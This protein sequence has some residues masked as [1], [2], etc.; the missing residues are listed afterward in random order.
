MIKGIQSDF[1]YDENL[2]HEFFFIA[3]SS[4][5]I[6]TRRYQKIQD[7]LAILGGISSTYILFSR[8]LLSNYTK[9][10]LVTNVL[11]HLFIFEQPKK[12]LK[13]KKIKRI[14]SKNKFKQEKIEINPKSIEESSSKT[15]PKEELKSSENKQNEIEYN[16][17]KSQGEI[18]SSYVNKKIQYDLSP[19]LEK[20]LNSEKK[21]STN[22]EKRE[23]QQF[24]SYFRY[25]LYQIK[26]V[27]HIRLKKKEQ[28]IDTSLQKFYSEM[29]ILRILKKL[30]EIDKLKTVIFDTPQKK[31]FDLLPQPLIKL[32]DKKDQETQNQTK[33]EIFEFIKNKKNSSMFASDIEHRLIDLMK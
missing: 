27:F 13:T 3:D 5:Q 26:K 24:F 12:G 19:K 8:I 21:P 17:I 31:I 7:L 11:N 9:F 2:I 10:L 23:K 22:L 20:S 33:I 30:N 18:T 6:M 16:G 25:L 32:H 1:M 4:T 15:N 14:K 29:E 28:F